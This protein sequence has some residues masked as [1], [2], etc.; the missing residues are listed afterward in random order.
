MAVVRIPSEAV[1][2]PPVYYSFNEHHLD[3]PGTIAVGGQT[4]IDY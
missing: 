1:L 3:F 2:M 4:I